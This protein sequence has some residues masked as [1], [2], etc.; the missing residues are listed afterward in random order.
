MFTTTEHLLFPSLHFD[1]PER[2]CL[3]SYACMH[4]CC[5][6]AQITLGATITGPKCADIKVDFNFKLHWDVRTAYSRQAASCNVLFGFAY[7]YHGA[8][9]CM[10]QIVDP[11]SKLDFGRSTPVLQSALDDLK[12][13]T[14]NSICFKPLMCYSTVELLHFQW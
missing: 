8:D 2:R 5:S 1:Q 7:R 14:G 6:A 9:N 10:C 3:M 12:T 4:F 13:C 11:E